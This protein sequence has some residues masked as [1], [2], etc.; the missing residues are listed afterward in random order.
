MLT[1]CIGVMRKSLAFKRTGLFINFGSLV[2]ECAKDCGQDPGKP[3]IEKPAF[4]ERI[5]RNSG[6]LIA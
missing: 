5:K 1:L 2:Y 6:I 3:T 4:Y